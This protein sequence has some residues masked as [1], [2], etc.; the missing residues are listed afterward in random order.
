MDPSLY[1]LVDVTVR[2]I[3]N[4]K[5]ES[6]T[7]TAEDGTMDIKNWKLTWRAWDSRAGGLIGS[8]NSE[9]KEL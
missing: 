7:D 8:F 1:T 9:R 4:G 6:H 3:K 5:Y 2:E